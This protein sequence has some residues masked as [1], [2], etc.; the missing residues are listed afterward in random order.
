[1]A[2]EAHDA[3]DARRARR[4]GEPIVEWRVAVDDRVAARLDAGEDLGLGIG[5]LGERGEMAEMARG[6]RS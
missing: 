6:D 3:R 5:D 2:A 4:R 1:M